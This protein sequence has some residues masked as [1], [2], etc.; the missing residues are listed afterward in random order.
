MLFYYDKHPEHPPTHVVPRLAEA[1]A[2]TID[3]L[4]GMEKNNGN[5]RRNDNRL[6]PRFSQVEKLPPSQRKQIVQ[7]LDAF[8]ERER[9]KKAP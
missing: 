5:G 3:Q 9:L 7:I 6:R 2:V 8:L 4:L 1:L